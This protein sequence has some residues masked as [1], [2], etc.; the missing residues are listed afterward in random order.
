MA[1]ME[2]PVAG[3]TRHGW[4][5]ASVNRLCL[6]ARTFVHHTNGEE[7]EGESELPK[8]LRAELSR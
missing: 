3:D 5:K 4:G 2:C 8:A 1:N 7:S 6:H